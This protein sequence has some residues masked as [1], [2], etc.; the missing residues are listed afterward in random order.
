MRTAYQLGTNRSGKP[1][2]PIEISMTPMIDV[3]FL[4]LVFFVATS[5][6][7]VIEQLLPSGVSEVQSPSGGK[8]LPPPEPTDDAIEQVIVKLIQRPDTV[9][10]ILNGT[11]L[12]AMSELRD[13][14]MVIGQVRASVPVVIHPEL[15]VKAEDVVRAYDWARQAGLTRVYLATRR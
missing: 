5:S 11:Q 10:A 13:K 12:G 14:L 15:D 7:Q 4:L 9:D 3:I 2:R 8:E 1:R 6:F